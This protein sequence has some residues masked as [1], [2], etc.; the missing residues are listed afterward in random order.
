MLHPP[1]RSE[2]LHDEQPDSHGQCRNKLKHLCTRHIGQP[3]NNYY[4]SWHPAYRCYIL[5]SDLNVY[6][7]NSPTVTANAGTNLNTSA[8]GTSANQAT[9]I[10]ALG[11]LHTDA[12]SSIPI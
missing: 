4:G 7:T 9:I 11:T 8:L 5:H 2:R 1:F 12:T 6:M 10:T 3:S